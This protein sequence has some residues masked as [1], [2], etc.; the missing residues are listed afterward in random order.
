[1]TTIVDI[2]CHT[3]N[4]DDIPVRGFLQ[5]V[6]GEQHHLAR[7]LAHAIDRGIQRQAVS[8]RDEQRDLDRLLAPAPRGD[9][10]A[11]AAPY[12]DALEAI[13]T[14]DEIEAEADALLGEI[15]AERPDLVDNARA[16]LAGAPLPSPLD[17]SALAFPSLFGSDDVKRWLTWVTLFGK[18]R[19]ALTRLMIA[20]YPEVDLF[21]PLLVDLLG[22]GDASS[23][24]VLEQLGVAERISRLSIQGRLDAAVHPFV[25]FDPR[26]NGALALA[27]AGVHEHGCVGVKL[28]PPM[29]F[30]PIGNV[31]HPPYRMSRDEAYAVDMALHGLY[32]WCQAEQVPITFHSNPTNLADPTFGDNPSPRRWEQV[33]DRWDLRLNFGH[34][35]WAGSDH[36][37]PAAI[38]R[39][40]NGHDHVYADLGNHDLNDLDDTFTALGRLFTDAPTRM[41]KSRFMF[42]TDWYMVASHG[43]FEQFLARNRDAF[44]RYLG[45][46]GERF[47]GGAALS[48]LGFDDPTNANNR[49]LRRRYRQEGAV[50]PP[51][52]ADD[53]S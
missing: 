17:D 18:S 9:G 3:F 34:F 21:T 33:L 19:L 20:T 7:L 52:L 15:E 38:C 16:E 26:R 2:H 13:P 37:W 4:A 35:G 50:L 10:P 42:G 29:G 24:G 30:L 45:D 47:L 41:M 5:R 8:A 14:S 25:G 53:P 44:E 40:A 31:E 32:D 6:V 51:W 23:S 46:G 49:R 1:M 22:L 48:F 28:Y 11:M 39:L 12:A 43:D 36:G 27:Q